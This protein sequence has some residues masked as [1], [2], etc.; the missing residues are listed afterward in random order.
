[1]LPLSTSPNPPVLGVWFSHLKDKVVLKE[2]GL[3]KTTR[4]YYSWGLPCPSKMA[5]H[6]DWLR[7]VR[8]SLRVIW[9]PRAVYL[10][11]LP[12][13]SCLP[14][15]LPPLPTPPG[16]HL[17]FPPSP[18]FSFLFSFFFFNVWAEPEASHIVGLGLGSQPS[19]FSLLLWLWD[20]Y[21]SF[22]SCTQ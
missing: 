1:M 19:N 21:L 12:L 14:E 8:N 10:L 6:L 13:L 11:D 9:G 5:A 16:F 15:P 4:S 17:S 2:C 20:P 3:S 7:R 22:Y 18:F